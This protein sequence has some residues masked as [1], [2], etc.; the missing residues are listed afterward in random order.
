MKPTITKSADKLDHGLSLERPVWNSADIQLL[1]TGKQNLN[2][3]SEFVQARIFLAYKIFFNLARIEADPTLLSGRPGWKRK[4]K[5]VV[6]ARHLFGNR[7]IFWSHGNLKENCLRFLTETA[8]TVEAPLA[9]LTMESEK[10]RSLSNLGGPWPQIVQIAMDLETRG[11]TLILQGSQADRTTTPFSDIDLVLFGDHADSVHRRLKSELD[12]IILTADPL[13]HHGVFFYDNNLQN[14]YSESILPLNTFRHSVAL[15]KP[16]KLAFRVLNDKYSPAS[17]LWSSAQVL[18]GF[19]NGET[20]IRGLWDW[21]FK[22]SQFLMM[23][24]LLAAVLGEY[25][26]KG[27]SFVITAPLFSDPARQAIEELTRVRNEWCGA[28]VPDQ[29]VHKTSRLLG[30]LDHDPSPVPDRLASWKNP[31]FVQQAHS[32]LD[33]SLNL[34]GLN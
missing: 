15:A 18:K 34:A 28:V 14:C 11:A 32:F 7:C 4:V 1:K 22:I 5:L 31:R 9:T 20:S 13:Q 2:P 24:T 19:L 10:S 3:C 16:A 12:S 23:P 33:E 21:K 25:I 17:S 26:Y 29:Y 8:E 30:R 27:D 6:V